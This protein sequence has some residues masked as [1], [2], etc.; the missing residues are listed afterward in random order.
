LTGLTEIITI[1]IP[2][3]TYFVAANDTHWFPTGD[4]N[5]ILSWEASVAVPAGTCGGGT[6]RNQI[7][8]TF[9]VNAFSDP[10]VSPFFRFHYRDPAAKGK[11][12]TACNV[13]GPNRDRAD[14]CGAS[15]SSTVD[16]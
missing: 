16:P 11:P 9:H 13:P 3:A 5:S 14:V 15:W 2:D 6:M 1:P 7:G 10:H 4:Q 8:A 12:N